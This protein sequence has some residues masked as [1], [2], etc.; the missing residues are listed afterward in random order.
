M[1]QKPIY[2]NIK[3]AQNSTFLYLR[4]FIY[5]DSMLKTPL[6]ICI[7]LKIKLL[8]IIFK[9]IYGIDRAVI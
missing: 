1:Q 3:H 6:R 2:A 8:F 5:L 9:S 4:T 7:L